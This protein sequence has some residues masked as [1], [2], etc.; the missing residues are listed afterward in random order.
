[1]LKITTQKFEMLKNLKIKEWLISLQSINE[2][3][4]NHNL[5]I[6]KP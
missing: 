2:D 6:L 1:M 4:K 5:S 3:V